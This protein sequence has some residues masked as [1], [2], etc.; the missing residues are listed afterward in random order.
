MVLGRKP[1]TLCPLFVLPLPFIIAAGTMSLGVLGQDKEEI[2]IG[3]VQD[4]IGFRIGNEVLHPARRLGKGP[5]NQIL[6]LA[7]LE[8]IIAGTAD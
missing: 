6:P 7:A 1:Y 8:C 3:I 2:I 4:V 5:K